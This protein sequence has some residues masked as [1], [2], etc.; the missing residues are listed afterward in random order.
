MKN[1]TA[2]VA[3]GLAV[4][5]RL[6]AGAIAQEVL[7][8]PEPPFRGVIGETYK[9]SK[10]D[11]MHVIKTPLGAPNVLIILIDD[12]NYGQW[13]TFEVKFHAEP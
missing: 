6:S 13:G 10:M 3:L 4:I 1:R 8:R 7:P 12:S 11:V 9:D 5:A 2:F